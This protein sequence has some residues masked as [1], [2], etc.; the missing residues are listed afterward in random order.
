M[1]SFIAFHALSFIIII[2]PLCA[3]GTR[4]TEDTE[5]SPL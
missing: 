1:Y 4:L 2:K 5:T 3:Q